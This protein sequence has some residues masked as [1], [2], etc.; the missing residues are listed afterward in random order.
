M[1]I[2]GYVYCLNYLLGYERMILHI[3][4]KKSFVPLPITGNHAYYP[5]FP[6]LLIKK[7]RNILITRAM[8]GIGDLL[9][10]TPGIHALK[11]KYPAERIYLAI[12]KIYFPVFEHNPDMI[13][14]DIEKEP[15]NYTAY[16]KWYNFTDCPAARTE[17]LS[18]PRV[19]K[20]RIDIFAR[21]LGIKG[22]RLWRM[23]R[24]P[25]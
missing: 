25:R 3:P 11:Q 7:R 22:I 20:N 10:M 9:T 17:A 12:P 18:A 14:I 6:K 2:L 4:S 1:G 13:L 19:K 8:G 15:L 5:N 21:A 16:R 23:N 24:R